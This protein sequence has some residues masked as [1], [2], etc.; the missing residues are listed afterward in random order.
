MPGPIGPQDVRPSG[1]IIHRDERG[2][3]SQLVV[4][5]D[6]VEARGETETSVEL[7]MQARLAARATALGV[8]PRLTAERT[9]AVLR[10][11]LGAQP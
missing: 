5:G 11:R 6:L 10:E 9:I 8:L 4:R 3:V 1:L 2:F 7:E